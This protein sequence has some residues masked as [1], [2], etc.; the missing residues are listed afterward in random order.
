MHPKTLSLVSAGVVV[1]AVAALSVPAIAHHGPAFERVRDRVEQLERHD[2][3]HTERIA[4][5]RERLAALESEIA[6][7]EDVL[8]MHAQ[9][10]SSL[11]AT[12]D[13]LDDGLSAQ[14]EMIVDLVASDELLHDRIDGLDAATGQ[15]D[16]GGTYT[17]SIGA[18]QIETP[19]ACAGQPTTWAAAGSGLNC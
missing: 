3:R 5:A 19:D 17:G 8:T 6:V 13:Q 12:D 7:F 10:L 1:G 4:D 2:E 18:E 15:L 16:A 11:A 9:S 14:L